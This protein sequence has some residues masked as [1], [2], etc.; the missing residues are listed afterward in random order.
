MGRPTEYRAEYNKEA[1]KLCMLGA[2]DREL[3]DFFEVSEVTINA[4]KNAHPS[5]LKSI[6]AGKIQADA[7]VARRLYSRAIGYEHDA[8]K[9]IT[10][11]DGNG[12]GSHVEQVP[13]VERYAPDTTAAIFWLKNRRPEQWRDK[14]ETDHR[15]PDMTTEERTNRV[16]ALLQEAKARAGVNGNGNGHAPSS[17]G[18]GKHS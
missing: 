6:R 1:R 13:Y 2:T 3:A 16:A 14:Q 12:S 5:F 18:N 17:N 4:W 9:I 10:V 8:V 7:N 15:F 11:S